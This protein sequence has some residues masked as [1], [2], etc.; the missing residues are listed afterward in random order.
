MLEM[1][2]KSTFDFGS[3]G[4]MLEMRGKSTFD[5]GSNS[6]MLEMRGKGTSASG[7][8]EQMTWMQGANSF[9]LQKINRAVNS[10]KENHCSVRCLCAFKCRLY[11]PIP[12]SIRPNLYN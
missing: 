12:L 4:Q 3:N 9:D 6:Q 11:N 5:F 2:G 7:L 8:E 10:L 1:R